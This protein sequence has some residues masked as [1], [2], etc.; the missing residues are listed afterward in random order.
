MEENQIMS[1]RGGIHPPYYKHF[2]A[3][4]GIDYNFTPKMVVIPLSQH[5]GAPAAPV[6]KQETSLSE[7]S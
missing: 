4:A 7:G 1:F 6:S 5:I 2:S 3:A